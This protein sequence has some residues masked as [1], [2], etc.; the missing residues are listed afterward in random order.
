MENNKRTTKR[1]KEKN[2]T[3][4]GMLLYYL[5]SE[6]EEEKSNKL[7]KGIMVH[8]CNLFAHRPKAIGNSFWFQNRV[9]SVM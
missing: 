4:S 7:I 9:E 6:E 8:N 5:G 2:K 3:Y 1:D